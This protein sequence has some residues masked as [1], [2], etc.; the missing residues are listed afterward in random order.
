VSG[1]TCCLLDFFVVDAVVEEEI[2]DFFG[3][4]AL[5]FLEMGDLHTTDEDDV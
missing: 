1:S 5:F 3:F 4:E 2:H